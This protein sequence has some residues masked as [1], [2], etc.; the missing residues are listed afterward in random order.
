MASTS[1]YWEKR[2]LGAFIAG[3]FIWALRL[4]RSEA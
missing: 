4:R 3:R 1:F 2:V